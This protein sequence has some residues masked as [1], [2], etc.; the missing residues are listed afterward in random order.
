MRGVVEG[1]TQCFNKFENKANE[2]TKMKNI[3]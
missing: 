3:F 2:K 1:L